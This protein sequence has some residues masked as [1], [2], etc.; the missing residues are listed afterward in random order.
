MNPNGFE[1]Q[2]V[3]ICN[4]GDVQKYCH[5]EPYVLKQRIVFSKGEL[6]FLGVLKSK[7]V[8]SPLEAAILDF[9]IKGIVPLHVPL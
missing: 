5:D 6:R 7:M 9:S 1:S 8:A 4:V 3:Y 2:N